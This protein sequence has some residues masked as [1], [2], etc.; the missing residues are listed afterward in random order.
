LVLAGALLV[1]AGPTG[2]VLTTVDRDGLTTG[3]LYDV[4]VL[5]GA[6]SNPRA[7]STA[8]RNSPNMI[9][10][11]AL[12]TLYAVSQGNFPDGHLYTIDP[13][14]GAATYIA[15]LTEFV[16]VEGDIAMDPTTGTLYGLDG[17]GELFII[18]TTN[19]ACTIVGDLTLAG[20]SDH[21]AMAFNA[22][23]ELFVWDSFD[24]SV[25]HRVNKN[26]ASVISS[27]NLSMS[28][29]SEV[30]GMSFDPISGIAYLAAG[31]GANSKLYE[32]DTTGGL[33][34]LIG[35]TSGIPDAWT[36]DF[37]CTAGPLQ[38][39]APFIQIYESTGTTGALGYSPVDPDLL[40][41]LPGTLSATNKDYESN[42]GEYYDFFYSDA[43]GTPNP[44][45]SYLTIEARYDN[46]A[47]AGGGLNISGVRLDYFVGADDWANVVAS[48]D[49]LGSSTY[50]PGSGT[51][52]LGSNT[53]TTSTMGNTFGTTDRLRL[54]LGFPSSSCGHA[55]PYAFA[56]PAG[57][58]LTRAVMVLAFV[59]L[60]YVGLL[61][62]G[63]A[64]I[65]RAQRH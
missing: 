50:I 10:S 36:L 23:G 19:G 3:N 2:A 11:G 30:G 9:A 33:V 35:P 54:T 18:N 61:G 42:A 49:S 21:S 22:R 55:Y 16:V 20:N 34:T 15:D 31:S 47:P 28:P 44:L 45:G 60:A 1:C 8:P 62:S 65:P 29:G 46:P 39:V 26:D 64:G 63:V 52:A 43:D 32:V 57:S 6:G 40:A 5:S 27:V 13:A 37:V 17:N 4:S 48:F 51:R 24:S 7:V 25:L 56:V 58:H 59:L 38:N 14:S 41:R 53:T 12:G